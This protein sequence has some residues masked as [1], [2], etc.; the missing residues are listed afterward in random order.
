MKRR[1]RCPTSQKHA[2]LEGD[3]GPPGGRR[4]GSACEQ[5]QELSVSA[6]PAAC[7][8]K[9]PHPLARTAFPALRGT[10]EHADEQTLGAGAPPRTLQVAWHLILSFLFS[11]PQMHRD[12]PGLP[13]GGLVEGT[14][15]FFFSFL[16][17]SLSSSCSPIHGRFR[18]S[19]TGI[20]IDRRGPMA[21]QGWF[22]KRS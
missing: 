14:C 8:A 17:L 4:L 20:S 6:T 19:Q 11:F 21:Q 9:R 13:S 16:S 5:V 3:F 12:L 7:L 1:A 10:D 22:Q 2:L 15:I 18:V